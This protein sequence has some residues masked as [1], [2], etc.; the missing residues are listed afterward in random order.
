MACYITVKQ[1]VDRHALPHVDSVREANQG[2]VHPVSEHV[3]VYPLGHFSHARFEVFGRVVEVRA[4]QLGLALGEEGSGQSGTSWSSTHEPPNGAQTDMNA[5]NQ[6]VQRYGES[7]PHIT[8][9]GG[10]VS[11]F[12]CAVSYAG[13]V[14]HGRGHT[15]RESKRIAAESWMRRIRDCVTESFDAFRFRLLCCDPPLDTLC[16]VDGD[17]ASDMFRVWARRTSPQASVA[18]YVSGG[19]STHMPPERYVPR[20]KRG[21]VWVEKCTLQ[22]KNAADMAIAFRMGQ[23]CALLATRT[24][25]REILLLSRDDGFRMIE[26]CI[27][28]CV[29]GDSVVRLVRATEQLV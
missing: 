8:W 13:R 6:Y 16:V 11:G 14:A 17:H 1:L 4:V 29:G 20:C 28:Q 15:K 26:R 3:G 24:P 27:S 10:G 7:S 25:P 18:V 12:T 21:V 5:M 22:C 2:V 19:A 9:S 23:L